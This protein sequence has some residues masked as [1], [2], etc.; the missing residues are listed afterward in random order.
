MKK[1]VLICASALLAASSLAPGLR[2]DSLSVGVNVG[3]GDGHHR[4]SAHDEARIRREHRAYDHRLDKVQARI[5]RA[6][7]EGRYNA[8]EARRHRAEVAATRARYHDND[9]HSVRELS[10]GDRSSL[11]IELKGR[12]GLGVDVRKR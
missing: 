12:E 8:E 3:G 9:D 5:D 4:L 6:E 2:A 10:P 7:R 11:E 1:L